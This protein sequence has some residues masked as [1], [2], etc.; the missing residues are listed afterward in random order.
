MHQLSILVLLYNCGLEKSKTLSS[1]LNVNFLG[2]N[3]NLVIWNNG[4]EKL[5]GIDYFNNKSKNIEIEFIETLH[6]ESLSKIYNTFIENNN[7]SKYLILDHDSLLDQ[8]YINSVISSERNNISIPQIICDNIIRAPFI[9]G[10]VYDKKIIF[11]NTDLIISI[12]SGL[13]IGNDVVKEMKNEYGKVFDERFFL[14]GVD[15]SFFKRLNKC[16]KD[17]SFKICILPPIS[18]SLSRLETE[19]KLISRFR[20]IERSYDM[21]LSL[22][23][24]TRSYKIPI[25]LIKYF[26]ATLISYMTNKKR[27]YSFRLLMKSFLQGKHYRNKI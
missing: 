26:F 25:Y 17:N 6:N 15:T 1:L 14:Y 5:K 27:H 23:F 9:N 11:D 8:L 10:K 22:R 19:G 2:N 16:L 21:G 20:I 24:Y 18:H 7:S 13:V 3:V 12:G 4:P